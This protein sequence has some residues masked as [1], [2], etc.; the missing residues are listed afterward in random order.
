MNFS[1]A[2]GERITAII[3]TAVAVIILAGGVTAYQ[4][5]TAPVD[6]I[7]QLESDLR[8]QLEVA[9]KHDP[10]ERAARLVELSKVSQAWL[11][12]PQ[13]D[14]DREQLARWLLES[15]IRS[16]PGSLEPLPAMPTFG[17]KPQR[18]RAAT[19]DI[20]IDP[21]V[22]EKRS[23]PIPEPVAQPPTPTTLASAEI[24]HTTPEQVLDDTAVAGV[25]FS[26]QTNLEPGTTSSTN[27][28]QVTE[29]KP[30]KVAP[31]RINLTELAARIAG[32][33]GGLAEIEKKLSTIS[34]DDFGSL[35]EQLRQLETL[36]R[37]LRFVTLYYEALS[38]YE[39][40]A[41]AAPRTMTATLADIEQRLDR[42]QAEASDDFLGEFDATN[43]ERLGALRE[44]LTEVTARVS[45]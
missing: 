7:V 35:A 39:R 14:A 18:P 37:D 45:H 30:E 10:N 44:L 15:T 11:N 40:R 3:S 8:F 38:N 43:Q 20:L 4:T 5:H 17:A 41:I 19:L 2:P 6:D 12:S 42:A 28:R 32:Y 21:P 24:P 26:I 9:F 22:L 16:M 25:E 34:A 27:A 33:H 1:S 29:A 36:T 23:P 31:V 13:S